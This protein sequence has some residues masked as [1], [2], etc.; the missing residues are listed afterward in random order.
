MG[1]QLHVVPALGP[2]RTISDRLCGR[3]WQREATLNP[4]YLVGI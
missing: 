2:A 4:G 3:G 1:S